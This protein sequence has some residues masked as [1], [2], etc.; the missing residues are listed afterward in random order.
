MS[1][2]K[3]DICKPCF[4]YWFIAV[5]GRLGIALVCPSVRPSVRQSVSP[6]TNVECMKKTFNEHMLIHRLTYAHSAGMI[7]PDFLL[8]GNGCKLA[9]HW[10]SGYVS[11][12]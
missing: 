4:S 6:S 9:S 8:V 5:E 12:T 11:F 10:L 3:K 7:C 2:M 1:K